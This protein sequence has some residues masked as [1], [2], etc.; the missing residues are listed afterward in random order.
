[1]DK[2]KIVLFLAAVS[3]FLIALFAI[4]EALVKI[5]KTTEEIKLNKG[6]ISVFE[7][8][9]HIGKV[10]IDDPKCSDFNRFFGPQ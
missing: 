10:A 8:C 2:L 5:N 4:P 3:L 9:S 6:E 7:Y 1:M